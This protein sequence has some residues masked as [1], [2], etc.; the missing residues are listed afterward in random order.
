MKCTT[1]TDKS[2][3]YIH[4][5]TGFGL[6]AVLHSMVMSS[7]TALVTVWVNEATA[8]GPLDWGASATVSDSGPWPAEVLAV[9]QKLYGWF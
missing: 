5:T 7:L 6:P 4:V 1:N 2:H 3:W 9:T 8:A